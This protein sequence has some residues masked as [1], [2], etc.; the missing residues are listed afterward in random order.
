MIIINCVAIVSIVKMF[1]P[2]SRQNV[3]RKSISHEMIGL[4]I[5]LLKG[6]VMCSAG[7]YRNGVKQT[8]NR[9]QECETAKMTEN[10]RQSRRETK[11]ARNKNE[12]FSGSRA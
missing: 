12:T 11:K 8:V 2:F 5:V 10:G 9:I 6:I 7:R 1:A 4:L 3:S